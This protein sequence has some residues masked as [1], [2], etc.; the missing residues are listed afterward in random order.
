MTGNCSFYCLWL[1]EYSLYENKTLVSF[2]KDEPFSSF[3][4]E[5]QVLIP[6]DDWKICSNLRVMLN[7]ALFD[8]VY[9]LN[10]CRLCVLWCRQAHPMEGHSSVRSPPAQASLIWPKLWP[11]RPITPPSSPCLPRTSCLSGSAR[12]RSEFLRPSVC[13]S[14]RL[15]WTVAFELFSRLVKN[16]FDLARQ[17]KPSI[18]FIDE[19]DS[20]CGS[21][22]EN[23][24][25]AARRIKT[26]FLVQMQGETRFLKNTTS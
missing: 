13:V 9:V 17:H 7:I 24:S 21:R 16:L 5:V 3:W 11:P 18:I 23:E 1:Y 6:N 15:S 25:E 19:V 14:C 12:A 8:V 26:E 22:N 20:L 4:L 10:A 2:Q